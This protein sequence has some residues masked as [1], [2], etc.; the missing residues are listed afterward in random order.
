[1]I[2]QFLDKIKNKRE[3]FR[4]YKEDVEVRRMVDKQL[5]SPEER[6]LEEY[7][8]RERQER[9]KKELS[10]KRLSTHRKNVSSDM[11]SSKPN[12]LK[13]DSLMKSKYLFKTKEEKWKQKQSLM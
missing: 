7:K 6:E 12:R 10:K 5:K 1:M 9:I 3:R 8:E 2:K 4:E 13:G 11:F